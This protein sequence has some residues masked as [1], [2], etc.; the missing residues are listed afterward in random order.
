MYLESLFNEKD[1]DEDALWMAFI[2][3]DENFLGNH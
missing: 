2:E 3:N 1:V